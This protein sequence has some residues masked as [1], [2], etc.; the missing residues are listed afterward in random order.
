[1]PAYNAERYIGQSIDSILAQSYQ[2]WELVI[3]NDGST[4]R[5]PQIIAGYTDPRIKVFYQENGGEAVARN[6]ALEHASGKFLAFLD[7]DD[8]YLPQ[9]LEE[10]VTYLQ[11]HPEVDGV[12]TDG[13]YIDENGRQLKPL[14][15]RRR[16]PFEGDIFEEM[17]R[18]SDVFG[19]PV[20]IVLRKDMI[21]RN[22]LVFDTDIV[23][24]PDWDFFIRY[25]Q[26]AK[27]GFIR[28][29]TCE[30]R[31]H[32]TNISVTT[33]RQNRLLHLAKCREKAI[34]LQRFGECSIQ[35][36]V[37]AFYDLLVNLLTGYPERQVK[38][39]QWQEFNDLPASDQARLFRLMASEAL[40]RGERH[41]L[42]SKWLTYSRR[43]N[44]GDWRNSLL[45]S[46]YQISPHL[47]RLLIGTRA[48]LRP[49]I[50]DTTP[51][52]DLI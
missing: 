17:V 10:T 13:Y 45:H 2:S 11:A 5:T 21:S 1:M 39:T 9:H 46:A 37:Y 32:Q 18:A 42:I 16:G 33:A 25:S 49:Q 3:V 31:V 35:T 50:T 43:L 30:Y 19:A 27:F 47:C 22:D 8:L 29:I 26:M 28:Q 24:G 41:P 14:S 40:L 48:S 52:G 51:F 15:T 12:Y 36:R 7:A 4:D 34:K 20:C 23:I 6:T 44:P 38:I